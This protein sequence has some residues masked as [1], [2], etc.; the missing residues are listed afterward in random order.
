[1]VA[2]MMV[3]G[4]FITTW[5]PSAT[6]ESTSSFLQNLLHM[7]EET[8]Q[9]VNVLFRKSVHLV[10]YGVLAL[11]LYH[12]FLKKRFVKAFLLTLLVASIDEWMQVFIPNRTGAL[13]DVL[14]DGVGALIALLFIKYLKDRDRTKKPFEKQKTTRTP[15][16]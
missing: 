7:S 13:T 3:A 11:V 10:S 6:G 14:L 9:F 16:K 1:M 5:S 2:V 15:P 4:I 8:A 12:S